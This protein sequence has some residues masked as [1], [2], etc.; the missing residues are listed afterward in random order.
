[1][2][3]YIVICLYLVINISF[4]FA[5][6]SE[7]SCDK[8]PLPEEYVNVLNYGATPNDDTD[9]TT[10]IQAAIDATPSG[11][12]LYIPSG[13]YKINPIFYV[14]YYGLHL[15]S[16]MTLWMDD[17]AVLEALPT[18]HDRY[19]VLSLLTIEN[20]KVTG[21]T[22]K[23]ER[24]GHS[25][26][27]GEN[28]HVIYMSSVKNIEIQN[29]TVRDGWGDGIYITEWRKDDDPARPYDKL[30]IGIKI[31]NVLADNN[32][33]QGL[34]VTAADDVLVENSRFTNSNG[35]CVCSGIDLEPNRDLG[36]DPP[37]YTNFFVSNVT[38]RDC[39]ITGNHWHGINVYRANNSNTIEHNIIKGN[40]R[41]GVR[42]F[43]ADGTTVLKNWIG[44]NG[45]D[46]TYHGHFADI[47]LVSATNT[48]VEQNS[49]RECTP[50]DQAGV[51]LQ[52]VSAGN[53]II[54]N[55]ICMNRYII[56]DDTSD[57][58]FIDK[59]N[60]YCKRDPYSIST[61]ANIVQ[62]CITPLLLR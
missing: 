26:S 47:E 10:T 12:T 57:H 32:R 34:S 36:S 44:E 30:T 28:G 59:L 43:E 31:C 58:A 25:G 60:T 9:D 13:T 41:N 48:L 49:L 29:L 3:K 51:W 55:D 14:G 39:E 1:M 45:T 19:G 2:K 6:Q 37:T 16:D 7:A 54:D 27:I 40:Y 38:V 15:K 17:D 53:S 22:I 11:G 46:A 35:A 61:A 8:P 33:R 42:V 56:R 20:V 52:G 23:G 5:A 24:N 18:S 50:Y 21:G 62:T 4:S